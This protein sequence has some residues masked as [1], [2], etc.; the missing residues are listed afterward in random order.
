MLNDRPTM[1]DIIEWMDSDTLLLLFSM[2]LLCALLTE[3]G[4]FN[5]I[6][7]YV[8]KVGYQFFHFLLIFLFLYFLLMVLYTFN[9][10]FFED[11]KR[12]CMAVNLRLMCN[13]SCGLIHFRQC[14]YHFTNDTCYNKI[15]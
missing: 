6:A 4:I 9:W 12:P 8:F 15:M 2:M 10:I 14:D 5:Y 1:H 13:H 7:V 11:N 3:T